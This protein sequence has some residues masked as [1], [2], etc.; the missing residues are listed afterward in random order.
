MGV[1]CVF[2]IAMI[3]CMKILEKVLAPFAVR[4]EPA[5]KVQS[6]PKAAGSNDAVLAAAAVAAVAARCGK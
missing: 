2:L 6:K 3:F 4:F 5:P 1:V